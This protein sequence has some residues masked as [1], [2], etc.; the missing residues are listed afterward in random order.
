MTREHNRQRYLLI[1]FDGLRPDMVRPDLVPNLHEFAA[2]HARFAA[3]RC[4]FPSETYVNTASL[5][6]GCYPTDHGLVANVFSTADN[7]RAE[8]F[9]GFAV[10]SIE[11]LNQATG[12]RLFSVESAGEILG[13]TGRSMAVICTNSGGSARLLHHQVDRYSH[14][15]LCPYAVE[16]STPAARAAALLA[17][18]P[19]PAKRECPDIKGLTWATDILLDHLVAEGLPDVTVLWYGEPD[20]TYHM[21]GIGSPENLAA[22]RHADAQFGR[23]L[24]WWAA[25]GRPAGVQLLV[26]SDHGHV[27]ISHKVSVADYLTRRGFTVGSH[28]EDG[29]AAAML[30]DMT[31]HLMVR[32]RDPGLIRDIGRCLMEADWLGSLFVADADHGGVLPGAFSTG[33]AL[34]DHPRSPDLSWTFKVDERLNAFGFPG[35]SAHSIGLPVGGSIH[36]GLSEMEMR[37]VLMA[38]GTAFKPDFIG[39]APTCLTDI[40]PTILHGLNIKPPPAMSGRVLREALVERSEPP[41]VFEET[42]ETGQKAY[43]QYLKR[44][45]VDGRCYL[46]SGGRKS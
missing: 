31:T 4:T 23:V 25:E 2:G 46:I 28:F 5:L 21:C 19:G 8:W 38:G 16:T 39:A 26:A 34:A 43:H 29:V 44:A 33:A 20:S 6:T 30:P 22:L 10:D 9:K 17:A 1:A 27:T 36:G 24:D 18:H 15:N 40:M 7:G 41:T 14:L 3:H 13:R 32:G 12:G 42:I 45:Q 35:N 37:C 11:R